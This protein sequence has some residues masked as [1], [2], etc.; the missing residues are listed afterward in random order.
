MRFDFQSDIDLKFMVAEAIAIDHKRQSDI[1]F[2]F[3]TNFPSFDGGS[4]VPI[5]AILDE[6]LVPVLDSDGNY[7]L[8][9]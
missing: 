7:I 2:I 1:R 8:E 3:I 6:D 9:G 5:D 4:G